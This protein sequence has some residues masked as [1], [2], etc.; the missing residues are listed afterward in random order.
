MR[1][2]I[3][4]IVGLVMTFM[5]II[6]SFAADK[7]ARPRNSCYAPSTHFCNGCS[8]SCPAGQGAYCIPGQDGGGP[9]DIF[10]CYCAVSARCYCR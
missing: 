9:C 4:V 2:A 7:K 6:S 5:S 8:V 10:Q 1:Y 3:A